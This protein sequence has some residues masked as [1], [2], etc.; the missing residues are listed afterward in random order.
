MIKIVDQRY[1]TQVGGHGCLVAI[2]GFRRFERFEGM[3][4]VEV[5][6]SVH[7]VAGYGG[8]SCA[9][10]YEYNSPLSFYP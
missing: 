10:F 5:Q 6:G 8:L 1:P 7:C 3:A 2:D 9:P 4:S